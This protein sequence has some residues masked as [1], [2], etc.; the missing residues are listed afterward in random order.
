MKIK[1]TFIRSRLIALSLLGFIVPTFSQATDID[2]E[3]EK[4]VMDLYKVYQE[5]QN[6]ST[7]YSGRWAPTP[8]GDLPAQL[9][10]AKKIEEIIVPKANAIIKSLT[11]SM[12]LGMDG[13]LS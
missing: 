12:V 6:L 5:I 3:T 13:I 10:T 1:T 7:T 11:A 8:K 4:Q 9:E 2:A